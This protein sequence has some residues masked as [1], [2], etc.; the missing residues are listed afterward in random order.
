M[1]TLLLLSPIAFTGQNVG[2]F[3]FWVFLL[4]EGK[5]TPNPEQLIHSR[6]SLS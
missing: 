1:K 4:N 3:V 5:K 2:V 6:F